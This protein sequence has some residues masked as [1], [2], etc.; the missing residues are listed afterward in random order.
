MCLNVCNIGLKKFPDE[1]NLLC[2]KARTSI[3]LKLF[4][5]ANKNLKKAIQI[6]SDFIMARDTHGDLLLIQGKPIEALKEYKHV[7]EL[8]PNHFQIEEKIKRA[9]TVRQEL[10]NLLND[11]AKKKDK[12]SQK[13][14]SFKDEIKKAVAF[15]KEGSKQEAEDIYRDILKKDSGHVEAS[16]LLAR[17]A[18]DY[19]HYKDAEIFLKNALKKAPD[20][21]R[22]WSDLVRAQQEQDK[23][24]EATES[25]EQ[26]VIINPDFPESHMIYAGA[27]GAAGDH[28]GAIKAYQQVIELDANKPGAYSSMAHHLKTIGQTEEAIKAYRQSIKI[29][30]DHTEAYWSLANLKTF[31]FED[32]EINTMKRLLKDNNLSDE[33]RVHLNNALGFEYESQENFRKAF[34]HFHECNLL[35]RKSESYDPVETVNQHEKI[36]S[37]FNEN[38]FRKST[39]TKSDVTPIFI[40]GLPRSGS[41]LIEQILSSHSQIEGTYELNDLPKTINSIRRKHASEK[42]TFPEGVKDFTTEQWQAIGNEYLESTKQ[43]RTEKPFFIDKTPNNFIFVGAL[44]LAIPNAKIINARRHPLDSCLGSYKQLF[45][46]GQPFT[47]DLFELGEYYLEYQKL[48]DFWHKTLPD[49][50]LDVHYEDVV[51][52]LEEEILRILEFCELPF[53]EDCIYFYKTKRAVKTASSEQVRQ[54]IYSSSVDLWKKYEDHLGDLIETLGDLLLKLPINQQPKAIS[55][56]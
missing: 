13:R 46:S 40:V 41:T 23:H 26:L 54:P 45:A 16:T 25:A 15:E 10:E 30:P 17:I 32:R 7:R 20:Y 3:T 11:R 18:M 39:T 52:N 12:A 9:E 19:Q 24:H 8:D 22:A 43:Y 36:I 4:N 21:A 1:L 44:K 53:E 42:R 37:T 6:D 5:E 28:H 33:A 14:M 51:Q 34:A 38:I 2:L 29:K 31:K 50:V 27:V 48:M 56:S 35:R 55:K 47:Y 49:F